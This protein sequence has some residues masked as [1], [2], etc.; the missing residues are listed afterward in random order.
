MVLMQFPASTEQPGDA[1]LVQLITHDCMI[2]VAV[3]E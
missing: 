1:E 2:G 3:S